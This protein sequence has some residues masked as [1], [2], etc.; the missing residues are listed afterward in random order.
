MWINEEMKCLWQINSSFWNQCQSLMLKNSF[1]QQHY[2]QSAA[3][4][5]TEIY[6]WRCSTAKTKLSI[7]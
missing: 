4:V 6:R 1:H 7:N 5:G 3:E 2:A